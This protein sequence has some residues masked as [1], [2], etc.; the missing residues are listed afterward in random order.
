MEFKWDEKTGDITSSDLLPTKYNVSGKLHGYGGGAAVV[1]VDRRII[2]TD[3]NSNGVFLSE[4]GSSDVKSAYVLGSPRA[5][6]ADFDVQVDGNGIL[7]DWILAVKEE[8][9]EDGRE[10]KNYIVAIHQI[11]KREVVVVEGA[12]FYSHPRFSKDG[13]KV[14]WVQWFHPDM[15]WTGSELYVADWNGGEILKGK[16]V[17]GKAS[18]QAICQPRWGL[19]GDLWFVNDPNGIWQM[20]RYNVKNEVVEPVVLKGYEDVEIGAREQ[21]LGK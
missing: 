2:F 8:S 12:D 19:D 20:F 3:A 15:P 17:A 11:D 18:D 4:P 14:A 10:E 6:Y 21:K 13:K 5:L 7:G 1:G 16:Y 9:F